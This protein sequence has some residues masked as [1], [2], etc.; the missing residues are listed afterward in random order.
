[1]T[2]ASFE[3]EVT[4]SS[5]TQFAELSGDWNPLHTDVEYAARSSYGKRVLHGA[6][7]AGLVSRMAG[8]HVPGT[9][10]L[11]HGIQLR[12]VAPI[13]P[14]ARL[15]VHGQLSRGS[16][17]QGV[18]DVTVV[19]AASGMRY[20]EGSY[21]FGLHDTPDNSAPASA[22]A[23]PP[24]AEQHLEA[25]VLVTGA[26]GALGSAVL[27]SLGARALGVS[28]HA[29]TSG[30]LVPDLAEISQAVGAR[31][32][33]GVVHCAWPPPDNTRLVD[34]Q[35]AAA[36]VDHYVG[37]PLR[38]VLA[39]AQL[40]KTNGTAGAPLI[41]VGS[42]AAMPGRH[43]YRMPL[44]SLGKALVPELTRMLALELAPTGGRCLSAIFDVLDGGMNAQMPKTARLA[45]MNRIPAGRI[46]TTDEAAQQLVWMLDNASHLAT[47]AVISLSGGAMP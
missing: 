34:L 17:E 44:Y 39:L 11:L 27:A 30:I 29:G 37:A 31:K 7:S 16:M 8:M 25:V 45:H 26:N 3:V 35:A 2:S 23:S 33:A 1:M 32:L 18:V 36:P 9:A 42:T 38:Q 43:N 15:L 12:F 10:C 46:A 28:R 24:E 19:D 13:L 5:A 47:G 20:V 22:L 4:D 21:S 40:L 41:L 6:F 14:P